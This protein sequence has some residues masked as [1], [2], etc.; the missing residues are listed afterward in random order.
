VNCCGQEGR[1][2][3]AAGGL[4]MWLQIVGVV[5]RMSAGAAL[6]AVPGALYAG[7]VG[8]LHFVLHGRWDRVP[9]FAVGCVLVGGLLGLL[10]SIPWVLAWNAASASS[11]LSDA[12]YSVP[13]G[14]Q[15][16]KES[17]QVPLGEPARSADSDPLG[18]RERPHPRR[19]GLVERSTSSC[20]ERRSS[21]P[22]GQ[23]RRLANS[24]QDPGV[25]SRPDRLRQARWSV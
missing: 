7:M 1:R 11:P 12:R 18:R 5:G 24:P 25:R 19:S 14:N 6:G 10:G 15:G 20:S 16:G 2:K 4:V 21:S 9:A 3:V 8:G 13:S 23:A 17:S 22:P